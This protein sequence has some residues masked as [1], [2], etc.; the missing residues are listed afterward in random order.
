MEFDIFSPEN[1]GEINLLKER[2]TQIIS[3]SDA[4]L[5]DTRVDCIVDRMARNVLMKFKKEILYTDQCSIK[6]PLDWIESF[7][8]R[9]FPE[10]LIK[11]Y[12]I[13]YKVYNVREYYPYIAIPGQKA[14]IKF[15]EAIW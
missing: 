5:V 1:C 2:L 11:K 6:H 3:L 9:W 7:K 13:K 4:L 14:T 15:K 12:P 8:E 10:W